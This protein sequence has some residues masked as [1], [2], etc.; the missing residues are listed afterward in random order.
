M[1]R[2]LF[3]L[4][5]SKKEQ[6]SLFMET[7]TMSGSSEIAHLTSMYAN[8]HHAKVHSFERIDTVYTEQYIIDTYKTSMQGNFN[9]LL[10]TI[11]DIESS[12][13]QSALVSVDFYTEEDRRNKK[14]MLSASLFFRNARRK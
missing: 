9:Q 7:S 4:R 2:E 13:Q 11:K 10:Y 12:V 3:L 8:A 5:K 14:L 6:D 1:R